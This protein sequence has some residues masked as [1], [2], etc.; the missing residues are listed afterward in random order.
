MPD[1]PVV[2]SL[3]RDA[4]SARRRGLLSELLQQSAERELLQDGLR[5]RFMASAETL[6]RIAQAI[7]AER[8]CCRFRRFTLSVEP[9][10]GPLTLDLTGP[11]G[12][13]D[14]VAAL[15]DL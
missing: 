3:G 11:Q 10:E 2:C 5:L 7:E 15:L 8:H 1:L 12:T 6:S 4:L 14:F 9:D 13:R